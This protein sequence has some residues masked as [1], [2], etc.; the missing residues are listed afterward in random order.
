MLTSQTSTTSYYYITCIIYISLYNF[1]EQLPISTFLQQKNEF[2]KNW[3]SLGEISVYNL[4][5]ITDV[6]GFFY[7]L[8]IKNFKN[9]Y[10]KEKIFKFSAIKQNENFY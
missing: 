4:Q 6:I 3:L 8:K 1:R 10:C 9:N 2:Y 7:K 5:F